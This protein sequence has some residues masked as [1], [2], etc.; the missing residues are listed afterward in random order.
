MSSY[1]AYPPPRP[2]RTVYLIPILLLLLILEIGG[3]AAW[4]YWS[5]DSGPTHDSEAVPR[6]VTAR[7]DLVQDE[8][9]TIELYKK[10]RPSV[11]HITTL[12]LRRSAYSLNVEEVPEGTGSGFLWDDLGHVVT[13]FHV[14]QNV[15]RDN[16]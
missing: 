12:G 3:V 16:T 6:A 1:D 9:A 15:R 10:A 14:I 4:W 13:N 8:Q 7:G 5:R 2:P 11:V